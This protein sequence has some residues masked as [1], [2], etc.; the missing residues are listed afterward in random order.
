MKSRYLP[1]QYWLRCPRM[2]PMEHHDA[3]VLRRFLCIL[4]NSSTR[5]FVAV[6]HSV[7]LDAACV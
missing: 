5:P 3:A 7:V 4:N 6:R 1:A 2:T